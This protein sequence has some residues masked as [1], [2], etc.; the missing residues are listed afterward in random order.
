MAMGRK[1]G[2]GSR[3][4]KP[5]KTTLAAREAFQAAFDKMGGARKLQEW[6]ET[7]RTE[8]YKLY[9]RLIP[10]DVNAKSEHSGAIDIR[11]KPPESS[12]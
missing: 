11:W 8:F 9:G 7:N 1:T 6:G 3:K 5:N 2:G 4:G 10:I 12:S